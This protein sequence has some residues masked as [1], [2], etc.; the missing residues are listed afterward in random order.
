ML[1]S[2]IIQTLLYNQGVPYHLIDSE[3]P[4]N[5]A[6]THASISLLKDASGI[7]MAIYNN[8]HQFD[9]LTLKTLIDRPK[10]RFMSIEELDETLTLLKNTKTKPF[11]NTQLSTHTHNDIQLIIDEPISTQS[12]ILLVTD[13]PEK[14]IQVDVWDIQV[15][16]EN[17]LIGG[18]F[19]HENKPKFPLTGSMHVSPLNIVAMK[20]PTFG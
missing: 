6:Q 13:N 5:L 20:K 4:E 2:S 15:M 12:M 1:L 3:N 8:D 14:R 16:V 18:I 19:S 7:V 9:L 11:N 17:A 10:L